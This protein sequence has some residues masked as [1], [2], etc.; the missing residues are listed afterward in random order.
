MKK[1][2]IYGMRFIRPNNILKKHKVEL[3]LEKEIPPDGY[4]CGEL[5]KLLKKYRDK[6]I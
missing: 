2:K 6:Y 4:S 3:L 1:N 5:I